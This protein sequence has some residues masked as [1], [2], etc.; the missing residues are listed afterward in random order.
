MIKDLE[1]TGVAFPLC[2]KALQHV[3]RTPGKTDEVKKES[4][5]F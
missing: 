2:V 3:Q 5:A 1:K 4:I